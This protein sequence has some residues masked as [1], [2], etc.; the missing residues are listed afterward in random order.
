MDERELNIL[1]ERIE[2]EIDRKLTSEELRLLALSQHLFEEA[3][4]PHGPAQ[5]W[6]LSN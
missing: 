1:R 3:P 5:R 4:T 6:P 2:A